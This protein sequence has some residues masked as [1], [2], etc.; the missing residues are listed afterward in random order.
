MKR[1]DFVDFFTKFNRVVRPPAL[2]DFLV[3]LLKTIQKFPQNLT[4]ASVSLYWVAFGVVRNYRQEQELTLLSDR[5]GY[6]HTVL[7]K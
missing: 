3:D 7:D 6:F 1:A 2:L 4:F 5:E